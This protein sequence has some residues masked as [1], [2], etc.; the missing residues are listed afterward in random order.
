MNDL[1]EPF[2]QLGLRADVHRDSLLASGADYAALLGASATEYGRWLTKEHPAQASYRIV[3]SRCAALFDRIVSTYG[4]TAGE[5]FLQLV[6]AQEIL[7]LP[8]RLRSADIPRSVLPA[9]TRVVQRMLDDLAAPRIGYFNHDNDPFA[10]DLAVCRLKMLPCGIEMV[11]MDMAF[12]RSALW[13]HGARVTWHLGQA[14]LSMGN[15]RPMLGSH[16]DRRAI[17]EFNP[18]GY[19]R[20]YHIVADILRLRP[21]IRGLMA[22]AWLLDPAVGCISPELAFLHD[23]PAAAGAVFFPAPDDQAAVADAIRMSPHRRR[24]YEAGEFKPC[25]YVLVWPRNALLGWAES[26]PL[27]AQ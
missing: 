1:A 18:E 27:Q 11:D 26:H 5:Q 6:A 24:L 17:R 2:L 20:F 22:Q 3:P 4:S 14:L 13:K 8:D 10:K 19:L 15:N 23:V 7:A 25:A 21:D 12:P 9:I 16:I